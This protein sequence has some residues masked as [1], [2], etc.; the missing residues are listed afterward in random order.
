MGEEVCVQRSEGRVAQVEGTASAKALRGAGAGSE[1]LLP[2]ELG[3]A[4]WLGFMMERR[5]GEWQ[6]GASRHCSWCPGYP[7]V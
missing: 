2:E 1:P 6:A 3:A 4:L 5:W 7:R